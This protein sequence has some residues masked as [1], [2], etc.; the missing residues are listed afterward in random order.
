M[1]DVSDDDMLSDAKADAEERDYRS[2]AERDGL[3]AQIAELQTKLDGRKAVAAEVAALEERFADDPD[4]EKLRLELHVARV[5]AGWSEFRIDSVSGVDPRDVIP[6]VT[7]REVIRTEEWSGPTE[8]PDQTWLRP[9]ANKTPKIGNH[10]ICDDGKWRR[11][12][13][14][15]L[16]VVAVEDLAHL[17]SIVKRMEDMIL[18]KPDASGMLLATIFDERMH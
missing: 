12:V 7:S 5:K 14:Q 11:D 3:L 15:K 4:N 8:T 2:D 9:V 10:R 6:W 13:V 17:C 18:S 16:D 1:E